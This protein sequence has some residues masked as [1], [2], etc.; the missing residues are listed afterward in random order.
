[1]YYFKDIKILSVCTLFFI[2]LTNQAIGQI[3]FRFGLYQ[4]P[5]NEKSIREGKSD[6]VIHEP[7]ALLLP[8]KR[9]QLKPLTLPDSLGGERY[10][11]LIC[12]SVWLDSNGCYLSI[13]PIGISLFKKGTIHLKV[14]IEEF[15]EDRLASY[16]SDSHR[17]TKDWNH[18]NIPVEKY[19][20]WLRYVI[21]KTY[22][23]KR[24]RYPPPPGRE[25]FPIRKENDIIFYTTID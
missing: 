4:F 14:S 23:Y 22:R 2:C 8:F 21:P 9:Y 7:P 12:I 3:P 19:L 15:K 16:Y 5:K 20:Q 25:Y 1:M 10:S 18:M 24:I 13:Q 17:Q 6:G 11:A